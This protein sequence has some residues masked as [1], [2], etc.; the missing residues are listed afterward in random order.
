LA[1][2]IEEERMHNP[3]RP[4]I[5]AVVACC[6]GLAFGPLCHADDGIGRGA[7]LAH[8]CTVCHGREG[9][10]S[11]GIP[12]IRGLDRKDI[13]ESLKGFR[14]GEETQTIMGR[15]VQEFNDGDIELLA[16]HFSALR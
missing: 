5:L 14:S 4:N 12:K 6:S 11:L 8:N 9:Q 13:T 10:G 7:I 15:L 1:Q 16:S 3:I 2:T